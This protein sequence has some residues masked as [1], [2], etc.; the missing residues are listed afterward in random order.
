MAPHRLGPGGHDQIVGFFEATA[1]FF[2]IDAVPNIFRRNAADEA[3]DQPAVAEAVDH[4]VFFG[5]AH[6]M[7]A[8]RQNVAEDAD[9]YLLGFLAQR[10][11]DQIGR[12]HRAVG[13][14]V[15]LVEDHAVETQFLAV[16]HLLEVLGVVRGAF[17]RIEIAARHRRARRVVGNMG[18]GEQIEVIKFHGI[19][20]P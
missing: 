3:G 17:G 16:G 9:L 11:G 5:D 20:S 6:R 2:R 10:G 19:S 15:V 8:Q 7:I 18:I 12:R 13:A 14:V 4:G 1:G